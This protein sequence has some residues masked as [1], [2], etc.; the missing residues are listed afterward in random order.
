MMI[1]I[2]LNKVKIY[3]LRYNKNKMEAIYNEK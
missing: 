1:I 3:I 2:E